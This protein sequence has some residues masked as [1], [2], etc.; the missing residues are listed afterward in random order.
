MNNNANAVCCTNEGG[1]GLQ[2]QEEV[3]QESFCNI[4]ICLM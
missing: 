2:L 1:D 4:D 3:T